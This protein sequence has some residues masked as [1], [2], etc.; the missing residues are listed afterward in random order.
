MSD[1]TS[2]NG[3]LNLLGTVQQD[4]VTGFKGV[5]MSVAFDATGLVTALLQKQSSEFSHSE[6]EWFDITRI[7]PAD[8]Y[9]RVLEVPSFD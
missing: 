5:V 2:G 8:G 9:D 7:K 3:R 4:K 1:T 6:T